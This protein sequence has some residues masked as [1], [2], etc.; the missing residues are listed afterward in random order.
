M[1]T[2]CK[3][4]EER[5]S[6][7]RSEADLPDRRWSDGEGFSQGTAGVKAKVKVQKY[8]K[9]KKGKKGK[10]TKR[11]PLGKVTVTIKVKKAPAKKGKKAKRFVTLTLHA[12]ATTGY[13]AFSL[14]KKYSVK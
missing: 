1:R 4:Q 3:G 6:N 2:T 7:H 12:P 5:Q 10:K 8:T 13:E 9:P 14:M 11:K